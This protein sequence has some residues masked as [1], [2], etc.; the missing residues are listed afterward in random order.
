MTRVFLRAPE[1]KLD[2]AQLVLGRAGVENVPSSIGRHPLRLR[3]LDPDVTVMIVFWVEE[4]HHL[5]LRQVHE[6]LRPFQ[7]AVHWFHADAVLWSTQPF[8]PAVAD[9]V[10]KS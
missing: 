5:W 2:I 7:G 4:R 9:K 3:N 1:V 10:L 6:E 8:T